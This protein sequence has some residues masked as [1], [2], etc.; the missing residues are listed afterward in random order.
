[1]P[2][3]TAISIDQK[4]ELRSYKALNSSFSNKALR[5]WF[6][7]RHNQKIAL[8]S[9]SEILS[10][11]YEHLDQFIN[12]GLNQKRYRREHWPELE[13]AL[14]M[15]IQQAETSITLTREILQIKAEFF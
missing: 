2:R 1:M 10:K 13:T 15:W 3:R 9:I 8:S 6:E 14:Y 11:R 5:Q 12:R 7:A 4:K